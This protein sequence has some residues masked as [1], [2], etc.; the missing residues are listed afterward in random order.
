MSNGARKREAWLNNKV[1]IITCASFILMTGL[2]EEVCPFRT[3]KQIQW[4]FCQDQLNEQ[5]SILFSPEPK[6]NQCSI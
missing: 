3:L 4:R 2:R 1:S 5:T 6:T